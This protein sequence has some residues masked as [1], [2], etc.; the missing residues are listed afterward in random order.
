MRQ[1]IEPPRQ[2]SSIVIDT[3]CVYLLC[4]K[5]VI[6]TACVYLLRLTLLF[7]YL[8]VDLCAW[9]RICAHVAGQQKFARRRTTKSRV[10]LFIFHIITI[11][12]VLG[13]HVKIRLVY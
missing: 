2:T 13:I 6:D 10:I 4:L 8:V 5:L 11:V 9:N 12:Q 7:S 1:P 3:T